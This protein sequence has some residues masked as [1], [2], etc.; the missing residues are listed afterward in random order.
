MSLPK[1]EL[2]LSAPCA[3]WLKVSFHASVDNAARSL[4]SARLA[5]FMTRTGIKSVVSPRLIGLQHPAG[6]APFEI[7]LITTWVSAQPEVQVITF[8]PPVPTL[9]NL[10]TRHG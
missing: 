6:L 1:R 7:S 2:E 5:G 4:F 8:V 10:G 3:V 9:R